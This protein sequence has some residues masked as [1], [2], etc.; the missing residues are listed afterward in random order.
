M[1]PDSTGSREHHI[2]RLHAVAFAAVVVA[3]LTVARS[4]AAERPNFSGTW[5]LDKVASKIVTASQG[6]TSLVIQHDDPV[7]RITSRITPELTDDRTYQLDGVEHATDVMGIPLRVTSAWEGSILSTR[8][9]GAG[10][11]TVETWE[12]LDGGRTLAIDRT[13]SGTV[14]AKE[15]YVYRKR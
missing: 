9:V 10:M 14:S 3:G 6:G 1:A 12:L 13:V 11:T 7:L 2:D 8:T 15:R 4:V 5:M